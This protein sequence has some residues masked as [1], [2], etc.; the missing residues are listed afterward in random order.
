ARSAAS[1][2]ARPHAPRR[3]WPRGVPAA[4]RRGRN[5]AD[6]H[7]DRQG[8]GR[9]PD[10]R[11]GDGR[12]R[13]PAEAVQSARARRADPRGIA[14]A[15]RAP[16]PRRADE[17]GPHPVRRPPARSRRAHARARWRGQVAHDRRVLADQRFR[18]ASA[19]TAR[20]RKADAARARAGS[21][22]VR[23]R[24]RRPGIAAAQAHRA[25][26]RG[27]TL[28][29]DRVGLRVRLC[30]GRHRSG[31]SGDPSRWRESGR[32]AVTLWPRSLFGRL[33]LMLVK[34]VALAALTTILVFNRDRA[35]LIAHQFNDTKVV[36]M[37]ALRAS[38]EGVDGPLRRDTLARLGRE[39]GVRIIPESER[40]TIGVAPIGA[41]MQ[42]LQQRLRED[43]GQGTEVRI[44]PH[45]RQLF[46]RVQAGSDGYWIGFPL[47]PR[48]SAEDVP[49][50]ALAWAT[51][52]IVL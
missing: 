32:G 39:Y 48:P 5:G 24:D 50:R 11:T 17:R 27:A 2:G 28:H 12:G 9:R 26:S 23:S 19:A 6:H 1:A 40:P 44:A 49:T 51:T 43:L 31:G 46:V 15:R 8:G 38:L 7:A 37:K 34:V 33:V 10:R 25:R 13:L 36:Q 4:A 20:A 16:H 21:R 41:T 18:A 14:P 42:G 52:I 45:A 47:P 29:P 22:G 30:P 35:A 3:G